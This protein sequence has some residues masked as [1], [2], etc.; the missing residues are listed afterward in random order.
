LLAK[1][2]KDIAK[3]LVLPLPVCVV[4]VDVVLVAMINC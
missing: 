1:N 4:A 3:L 2:E